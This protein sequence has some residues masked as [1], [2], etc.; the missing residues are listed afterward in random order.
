MTK[1]E[2]RILTEKVALE[3]REEMER[4][5][6]IFGPFHSLHE[7]IAV[8]REEYLELEAAIFWGNKNGG[9][10]ATVRLEALH[11]AAMATRLLMMLTPS[12]DVRFHLSDAEGEVD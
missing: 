12:P 10:N 4:A 7:A 8:I 3:I 11:T 6:A 5:E 9:N 2:Q 1:T